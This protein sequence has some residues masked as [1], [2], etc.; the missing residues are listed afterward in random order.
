M[1]R[2]SQFTL[3]LN[4]K[5]IQVLLF[6]CLLHYL[7]GYPTPH[8]VGP[9]IVEQRH[10]GGQIVANP[11]EEPV[12]LT[13][14]KQSFFDEENSKNVREVALEQRNGDKNPVFLISYEVVGDK[15]IGTVKE[16]V[17]NGEAEDTVETEL[18]SL[19]SQ[20]LGYLVTAIIYVALLI[21]LIC[22]L[23]CVWILL[24]HFLNCFCAPF[25]FCCRRKKNSKER[26]VVYRL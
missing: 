5:I 24:K 12:L 8:M 23:S 1:D 17:Q 9:A 10:S 18:S 14:G 21:I 4:M 22:L 19:L 13:F 25:Q 11:D 20:L 2:S 6:N 3:K 16:V 15:I 7:S 26:Q